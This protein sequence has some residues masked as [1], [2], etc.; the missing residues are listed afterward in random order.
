MSRSSRKLEDR[1]RGTLP[2]SFGR[3]GGP[4]PGPKI[5]EACMTGHSE[6]PRSGTAVLD[7]AGEV[8]DGLAEDDA[9]LLE[10]IL[11]VGK[12]SFVSGLRKGEPPVFFAQVSE[13][14]RARALSMRRLLL[15]VPT[16]S[17]FSSSSSSQ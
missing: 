1:L 14:G 5:S 7:V 4:G 11:L 9:F 17:R 8:L 3:V 6:V 15:G 12:N 10:D 16:S 2:R 13:V